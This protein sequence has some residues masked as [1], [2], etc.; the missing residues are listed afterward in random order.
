MLEEK[1]PL[2][3]TAEELADFLRELHIKEEGIRAINET[4]PLEVQKGRLKQRITSRIENTGQAPKTAVWEAWIS[5]HRP[6]ILQKRP[7]GKYPTEEDF[8]KL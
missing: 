5:F 3:L 6:Q 8:L 4:Y 1:K 7:V 2:T